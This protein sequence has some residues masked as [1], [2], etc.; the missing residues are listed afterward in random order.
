MRAFKTVLV[1]LAVFLFLPAAVQ[2][3][4]A[5]KTAEEI[6]APIFPGPRGY[7]IALSEKSYDMV[8][9]FL[10]DTTKNTVEGRTIRTEYLA[11]GEGLTPKDIFEYY[12]KEILAKSGRVL[13]SGEETT[14]YRIFSFRMPEESNTLFVQGYVQ[15]HGE[16]F[17][18]TTVE[19]KGAASESDGAPM[20]V[21]EESDKGTTVYLTFDPWRATLRSDTDFILSYIADYIINSPS[22]KK[23]VIEGHS[24]NV[25]T[26]EANLKLSQQRA[27]AVAAELVKKGVP[28]D[29]LIAVGK[30]T[31]DPVASN[32]TE[33]GR[34]Q[35]RR[36]VVKTQQ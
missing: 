17:V 7:D 14:G 28:A 21:M 27:D 9:I 19:G 30:G 25:G 33:E 4:E 23:I 26:E 8:D 5:N 29:R 36:V 1:L 2:A 32:D 20:F 16:S 24:D 6:V 18:L 35:N 22:N 12:Q 11:K 3:A 15:G 13:F 10:S 31:A 34:A